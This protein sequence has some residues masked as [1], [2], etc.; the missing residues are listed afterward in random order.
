MRLAKSLA[1]VASFAPEKFEDLRRNVDPDWIEQALAASGTATLRRRRMPAAQVVWL[2]NGMALFRNRSIHDIVGKLNLVLPGRCATVA[3][4][5]VVEARARLG[6]EPL[7]W[8]F[9]RSAEEWAHKSARAHAWRG[10]ALYGSDGSVL[11]VADSIENREHFG[12]TTTHRGKS[13][14]P[15][16]RLV[17]L[18]ALRS[19]L[20]ASVA[21]GAYDNGEHAYAKELWPSVPDHSLTLIDRG[22]VAA[23]IL[24]PLARDGENRHWLTRAKKNLRWTVIEHLGKGDTLVE[25]KV[26]GQARK[27]DPTLPTTW[28]ARV[29]E[30]QIKGYRPQ[31]LLTSLLDP[32]LY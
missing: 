29:V 20:L 9:T 31:K 22:F 7:N 32:E 17:S 16:L 25:M 27:Q 11:R 2:V 6:E 30:Y 24:I 21:F 26:S 4:S 1:A 14:Y 5:S 28:R 10:L 23:G 12:G 13:G 15:L 8:I 3:A 19:H 18:M